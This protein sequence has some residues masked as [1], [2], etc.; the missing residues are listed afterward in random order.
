MGLREPHSFS[1]TIFVDEEEVDGSELRSILDEEHIEEPPASIPH[2]LELVLFELVEWL[3][4]VEL[5]LP[6]SLSH[7]CLDQI[8]LVIPVVGMF[9]V[10]K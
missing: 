5:S 8:W 4:F 7:F 3:A 9:W 1:S 2:P 10:C 6:V